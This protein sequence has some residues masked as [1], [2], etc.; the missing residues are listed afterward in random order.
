MAPNP[1]PIPDDERF[2]EVDPSD[3]ATVAGPAV[4]AP[5]APSS[6][7]IDLDA[8]DQPPARRR[9]G[10]LPWLLAALF[11][12]AFAA[13]LARTLD[14]RATIKRDLAVARDESA[15]LRGAIV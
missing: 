8:L 4:K 5:V 9:G 13:L 3:A 14:E 10:S 2:D 7:T 11:A 12:A 1:P 6:A 15:E